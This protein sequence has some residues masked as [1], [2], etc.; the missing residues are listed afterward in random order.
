MTKIKNE[1]IFFSLISTLTI[2][3]LSILMVF[4]N[5]LD[6]SDRADCKIIRIAGEAKVFLVEYPDYCQRFE[7]QKKLGG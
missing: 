3:Y 7:T 4:G 5:N 6:H 2:L 1:M